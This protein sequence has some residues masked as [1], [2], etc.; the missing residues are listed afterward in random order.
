ME[1]SNLTAPTSAPLTYM[2]ELLLRFVSEQV[3]TGLCRRD[4]EESD[5][6]VLFC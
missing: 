4:T 2:P 6:A 1:R 5:L 3:V